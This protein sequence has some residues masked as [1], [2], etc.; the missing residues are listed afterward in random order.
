[1]RIEILDLPAWSSGTEIICQS[2]EYDLAI[3][4]H[5]CFEVAEDFQRELRETSLSKDRGPTLE[6]IMRFRRGSDGY[7]TVP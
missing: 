1:M 4:M 3:D 2:T 7:S 6:N 5:G